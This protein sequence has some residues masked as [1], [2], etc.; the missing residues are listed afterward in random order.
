MDE[1]KYQVHVLLNN[2]FFFFNHGW[3]FIAGA[4]KKSQGEGKAFIFQVGK[5]LVI[6]GVSIDL[7]KAECLW[8]RKDN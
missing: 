2:L 5:G 4:K 7:Y 8:R 6:R 3:N 1:L